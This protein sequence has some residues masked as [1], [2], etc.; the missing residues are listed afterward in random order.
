MYDVWRDGG[1]ADLYSELG[2]RGLPA[3]A[4]GH[5][6]GEPA[7]AVVILRDGRL[8]LETGSHETRAF[9]SGEAVFER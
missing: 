8:E 2:P 4:P 3:W 6:D 1:L 9:D 7:T 5:V